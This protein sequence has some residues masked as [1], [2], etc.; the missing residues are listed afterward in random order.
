M[1]IRQR[2]WDRA[3]NS[4]FDIAI[5]GGGINGASIYRKLCE[6]G[7]RVFLA[8]KGDFS[9]GTSQASAMMIW[10][11][12]LYLKNLDLVSVCRF[13]RDRDILIRTFDDQIIPRDFRYIPNDEWG[14]NRYFVYLVLQ[15]Y[16]LLGKCR[17]KRPCFEKVF[18][19]LAL[20]PDRGRPGS[21]LYQEG[22]LKQSD[23]RFVLDWILCHQGE[24]SLALNYCTI[25][26]ARYNRRD[27]AWTLELS[28]PLSERGCTI[29]AKMILN[30]AGVWTDRVNERFGIRSPFRHVFSKGVFIGYRRPPEHRVPLIF[31]TGEEADTLTFIPWGPVSLWGPTETMVDSPESGFR[32]TSDDLAFLLEHA[33]RNLR[34]ALVDAQIVSLRCGVR[35]LAVRTSFRADCCPLDISRGHRIV[36][37]PRLPWI[38][39]YGGKISGCI[40]MAGQV[41]GKIA[42][43]ISPGARRPA[44]K[45][46]ESGPIPRTSFPGLRD[47]VVAIDWCVEHEFCCTLED[48]L[49]RRTNISQ[50]ICR[51][52]L[53]HRD[54]NLAH[55]RELAA[56]LP[57]AA[58]DGGRERHLREYR[59][60]VQDRFDAVL[61]QAGQAGPPRDPLHQ[62]GATQTQGRRS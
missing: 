16:W 24:D 23:S 5:I 36:E 34:P 8:D 14:R 44:R 40:S 25:E 18:P 46:M 32:I 43:R 57:V 52:G 13:S 38:S 29:R 59:R 15:L 53:G 41:A 55:L 2:N 20:I 33:R 62:T 58:G 26:E 51:Q 47:S 17:R 6:L 45:T 12:L 3:G 1:D 31:E 22:F 39:V 49:R 61:A 56:R 48:Y 10:G 30:C 21:L 7:F 50:W 37:D 9:C 54:A 28:D 19:E 27:R 11:G 60:Q 4:S 35:P 42:K